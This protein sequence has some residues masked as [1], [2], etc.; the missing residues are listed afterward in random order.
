MTP[1]LVPAADATP[2][3]SVLSSTALAGDFEDVVD[4]WL[5]TACMRDLVAW[6]FHATAAPTL[7]EDD[8]VLRGG[9][10]TARWI[11][12]RFSATSLTDWSRCSLEWELRHIA[13]AAMTPDDAGVARRLLD[14]RMV[15]RDELI[16]ELAHRL[17]RP[18]ERDPLVGGFTRRELQEHV[19]S[20]LTSGGVAAATSLLHDAVHLRPGDDELR[21]LLGF[22]LLTTA[23]SEALTHPDRATPNGNLSVE[24]LMANR[25]AAVLRSGD[26]AAATDLL[27]DLRDSDASQVYLLWEPTEIID[28]TAA[29][30]AIQEVTAAEWARSLLL[31]MES[32]SS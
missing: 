23:P 15:V 1:G 5:R 13:D 8:L 9:E 17:A 32:A 24:L 2:Q 6:T 10:E 19:L 12:E 20:L 14:E 22:C 30:S 29:P 4:E 11:C 3:F 27:V 25:A 26:A 18:A 31:M 7:D 28:L 16:G 21:N